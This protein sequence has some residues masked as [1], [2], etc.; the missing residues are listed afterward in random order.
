M[1]TM[2]Q[3][4]LILSTIFTGIF[5][6]KAASLLSMPFLTLFLFKNTQ[7][8][9]SVIGLIVGMQ[10][11]ALCFGSVIGGYFSDIFNWTLA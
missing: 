10:P 8:S 1:D 2:Q 6:T 3:Q 7:L 5:W 11:L 9:V 4:K